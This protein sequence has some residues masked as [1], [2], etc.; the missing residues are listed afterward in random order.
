[1]IVTEHNRVIIL[2]NT[3]SDQ[4]QVLKKLMDREAQKIPE[5]SFDPKTPY[6][7]EEDCLHHGLINFCADLEVDGYE[8][9]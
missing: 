9:S 3:T 7:Y 1:M 5:D 2:E 4:L 6:T 8:M